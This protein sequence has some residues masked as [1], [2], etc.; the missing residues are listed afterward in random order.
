[1]PNTEQFLG[2][3]RYHVPRFEA[4]ADS[5]QVMIRTGGRQCCRAHIIVQRPSCQ[6]ACPA[7]LQ[8]LMRRCPSQRHVIV[9]RHTLGAIC[10]GRSELRVVL[11]RR[12]RN[13][14]R[15]RLYGMSQ[16]VGRDT[17]GDQISSEKAAM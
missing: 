12:Q 14:L 17:H 10:F 13:G 2:W 7:A 1:M 9:R 11:L 4:T 16:C 6:L 3:N 5:L 15:S 8:R